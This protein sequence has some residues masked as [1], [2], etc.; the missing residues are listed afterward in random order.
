MASQMGFLLDQKWCIGCQSCVTGCQMRHRTPDEVQLRKATSF[1]QQPV[2]P[3]ITVACNHCADPACVSVCPT[4]ATAKREDGIVVHDPEVCIGCQSCIK[5]CPYEHPV[6]LEE[7]NRIIR[8]D[9]CA[10]RLDAGD[11]PACVEACPMKILTVDTVENNEAAG[12][13]PEGAGFTVESTNP[14]T[15]FI[16][17]R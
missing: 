11:V 3:W 10:A 16:P 14:T 6:Y 12:G 4:G 1:E 8:C 2:G 5:A 15:R 7:E 13:V 17:I 9:M